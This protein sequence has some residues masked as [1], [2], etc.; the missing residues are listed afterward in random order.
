VYARWQSYESRLKASHAAYQLRQLHS[1]EEGVVLVYS[2]TPL[3][4]GRYL[5]V[6]NAVEVRAAGVVRVTRSVERGWYE[7]KCVRG[8]LKAESR[9]LVKQ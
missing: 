8:D 7:V 2:A 9:A 4:V 1:R 5:P 6:V 3:E